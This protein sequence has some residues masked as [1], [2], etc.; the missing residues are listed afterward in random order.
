MRFV[1]IG[2]GV[3]LVAV[4]V[5]CFANPGITF[6]SFAFVLGMAMLIAGISN[7]ISSLLYKERFDKKTK[8]WADALKMSHNGWQLADGILSAILSAMLLT[9]L[10]ITEEMQVVFF[11]MWILTAG[12]LRI[13][14]SV[15]IGISGLKG[16]YFG[17]G[18]G[19]LSVGAG[20]FSFA[21]PMI[22]GLAMVSLIGLIFILQGANQIATGIY[23][24]KVQY[25]SELT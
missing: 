20:V 14:A 9:G 15:V 17:L 12:V 11:G 22:I 25:G 7:I 24:R 10:L 18:F 4:G 8:V 16:W 3:L 23:M 19:L 6:L 13:V 2:S 21:H 1:T 5:W